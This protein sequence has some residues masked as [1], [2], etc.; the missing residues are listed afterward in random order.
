MTETDESFLLRVIDALDGLQAG[1]L[2]HRRPMLASLLSIARSEAEDELR[3]GKAD[4]ALKAAFAA[5]SL[6]DF[7]ETMQSR[8]LRS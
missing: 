1:C 7:S 2:E 3:S 6:A 4:A 8:K 5:N